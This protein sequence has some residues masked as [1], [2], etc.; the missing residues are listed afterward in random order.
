MKWNRLTMA[1]GTI[2]IV[3]L[4]VAVKT[5]VTNMAGRI[6][7]IEPD[8][9]PAGAIVVL[10]SGLKADGSLTFESE[11]RLLFGMRL[12]KEGLA[13]VFVVSGPGR[14]NTAPEATVRARIAVE[15][16]IPQSRI[17]ELPHVNTTRDEAQQSQQLLGPL[18]IKHVLLVTESMHMRRSK[19]VFEAA[20]L[21]VSAAPSDNLADMAESPIDRLDLCARLL[22][23][24]AGLIYYRIAGYI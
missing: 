10:G 16:G 17:Y 9:R 20:G 11:Q 22:M 24:L 1:L 5:P 3:L 13:P 12:Y 2:A 15:M 6:F 21:T 8:L 23:H 18:G 4:L 19:A 7:A 14:L